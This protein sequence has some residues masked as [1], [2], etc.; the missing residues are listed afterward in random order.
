MSDLGTTYH[1]CSTSAV[2]RSV[3]FDGAD[4]GNSVRRHSRSRFLWKRRTDGDLN[5]LVSSNRYVFVWR[6]N[7]TTVERFRVWIFAREW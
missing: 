2:S 1:E 6:A 5:T 3:S 4:V 7:I